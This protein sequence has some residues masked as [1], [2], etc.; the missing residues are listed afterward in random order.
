MKILIG[1]FAFAIAFGV[2]SC[3]SEDTP[4]IPKTAEEIAIQ[5]E[6]GKTTNTGDE[7]EA[8]EVM[9]EYWEN[10]FISEGKF[11][12]EGGEGT[13]NANGSRVNCITPVAYNMGFSVYYVG[14][15]TI[16]GKRYSFEYYPS[17]PPEIEL[18]WNSNSPCQCP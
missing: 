9:A 15:V 7:Q 16:K 3:S 1:L 12:N 13:T 11:S 6:L 5:N 4:V 17:N 8:F 2:F 10:Y 14:C 18:T